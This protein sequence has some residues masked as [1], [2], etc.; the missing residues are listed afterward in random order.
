VYLAEDLAGAQR[1]LIELPPGAAVVTRAGEV[2]RHSGAVTAGV[3]SGAGAGLLSRE[4][5]WRELPAQMAVAQQHA[6]RIEAASDH[7]AA[8]QSALE[9][10]RAA[11]QRNVDDLGKRVRSRTQERDVLA[12]AAERLDQQIA[13]Q[14]R[15]IQQSQS[16]IDSLV[17]KDGA[18]AAELES[19]AAQHQAA[20][21]EIKSADGR[22]AALPLE[23]LTAQLAQLR[24]SIA[25]ASQA[26]QGQQAIV[27]N[28]RNALAQV[29]SQIAAR[30]SRAAQL[31][32][33]A[34]ELESRL[35]A[36]QAQAAD[37][38]GKV[39]E[40]DAQ[41]QP[42]Q[43]ELRR[44]EVE[45]QAIEDQEHTARQRLHESEAHHN[46]AVLE[47]GR[48]QDELNNLHGRID[49]DLGL[50]ELDMSE[51]AGPV[52]LPLK[53]IVEELPVVPEL[54]E[55]IEAGIQRRKAQLHRIGP[56]SPEVQQEFK[57][58]Q[59]RYDFLTAQNQ[60]LQKAIES[61]NQVIAELDELMRKSFVETFE[62]IAAEFKNT[63]ARLFGGGTAKIVLTDPENITTTGIDIVARP[64][65]KRQQGLALLSGGERSLAAAA[66]LFAILKVRPT[67]FCFLDEVDAA[68]DEANVGRFRD[69]LKE[70]SATT[71]FVIIT[72]NRGTVEA[73]DTIY[74]ITMGADSASRALSL[75]LEGETIA[76][77][78]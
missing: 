8:Q 5:E 60:D 63:F 34:A 23:G 35:A 6:S 48:R 55:G 10:D 73:A 11:I 36:Q 66:L 25:V 53:P 39:A 69:M 49:E 2:L 54:P 77:S 24:T 44:L 1:T 50:V 7:E 72:H 67:P 12:R 22:L 52:P 57:E 38:S 70:L 75:K 51:T 19:L 76:A 65:G 13:F 61:L 30:T 9:R 27:R 40:V 15:L 20:E 18:L 4:R 46:S 78:P 41:L 64:P 33:E 68:L 28:E 43:V 16:E 17:E 31:V 47:A 74:G 14:A 29:D 56:I 71:Q 59:E 62:A 37:A 45:Q 32:R 26:A 21:S 42:A 3:A 58:T